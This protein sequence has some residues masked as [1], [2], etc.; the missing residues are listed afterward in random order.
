[1]LQTNLPCVANNPTYQ[2]PWIAI[3]SLAFQPDARWLQLE[4]C[5]DHMVWERAWSWPF[6]FSFEASIHGPYSMQQE[7]D[8]FFGHHPRITQSALYLALHRRNHLFIIYR[9]CWTAAG[10]Q[11]RCYGASSAVGGRKQT[12]FLSTFGGKDLFTS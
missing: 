9:L 10:C 8:S 4:L 5:I 1:M 2:H 6:S 12:T 7:T 3:G 11:E